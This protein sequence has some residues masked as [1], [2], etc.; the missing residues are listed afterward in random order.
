MARLVGPCGMGPL[1]R[2]SGSQG[3]ELGITSESL[4]TGRAKNPFAPAAASLGW[5]GRAAQGRSC[6]RPAPTAGPRVPRAPQNAAA[7]P[8]P[9]LAPLS[10]PRWQPPAAQ[11]MQIVRAAAGA[12]G[13]NHRFH[14]RSGAAKRSCTTSSSASGGSSSPCSRQPLPHSMQGSASRFSQERLA[15]PQRAVLVQL[16]RL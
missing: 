3:P 6:G 9:I 7:P 16:W 11:S 2:P 8:R 1:L 14:R 13:K 4:R 10:A 15:G 12:G 5:W